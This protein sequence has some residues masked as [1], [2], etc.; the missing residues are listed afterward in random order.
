MSRS[1]ETA[2]SS[3]SGKAKVRTQATSQGVFGQQYKDI[4][5][6][7]LSS[8]ATGS[9]MHGLYVEGTLKQINDALDGLVYTPNMDFVGTDTLT[10]TTDDQH[11]TDP[12]TDVDSFDDYRRANQRRTGDQQSRAC[13]QFAGH[14]TYF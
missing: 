14:G 9:V 4:S 10:I 2:I 11:A 1:I 6:L 13:K 12:K 8:K 3:S 5:S 7:D